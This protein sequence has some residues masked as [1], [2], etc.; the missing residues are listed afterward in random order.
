MSVF[1]AIIVLNLIKVL[2]SSREMK[3][4]RI[5]HSLVTPW[6]EPFWVS[7]RIGIVAYICSCFI[8]Q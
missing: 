4:K 3:N 6:K 1:H 2:I 8:I 7:P 5:L